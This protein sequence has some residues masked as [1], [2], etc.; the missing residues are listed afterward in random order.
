[1]QAVWLSNERMTVRVLVSETMLI[2]EAAPIVQKF[3]GQRFENLARWMQ[4]M[5]ETE[6]VE[7]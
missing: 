2:L 4:H 1:M 7:L 6:I 3:I 5:G